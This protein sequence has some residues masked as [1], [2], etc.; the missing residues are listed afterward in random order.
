MEQIILQKFITRKDIQS[1]PKVLYVF[2][3]N[4]KRAGKGGQAKEMRGESNSIGI[5]VKKAP[6]TTQEVYYTDIE[7]LQNIEK[8]TADFKVIEEHLINGGIV[9]IP[10]DGIGTGLAK[11]IDTA[12]ITLQFVKGMVKEL[13]KRYGLKEAR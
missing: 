7:A 12:P 13:I 3:D 5:R 1:N 6:G 2:G 8:I 9:V 11:L 4:D 10:T